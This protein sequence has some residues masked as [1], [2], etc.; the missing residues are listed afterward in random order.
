MPTPTPYVSIQTRLIALVLA[1]V[2]LALTITG[3]TAFALERSRVQQRVTAVLERDAAEFEALATQG[4]NPETG[5]PFD[6]ARDLLRAALQ[7]RVQ[8]HCR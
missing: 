1:L 6:N 3:V 5:Q 8:R 2:A 7:Y 4:S